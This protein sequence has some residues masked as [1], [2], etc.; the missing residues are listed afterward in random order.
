MK[1]SYSLDE[2]D[3]ARGLAASQAQAAANRWA[4]SIAIVDAGGHL[5]AFLRLDG[6]AP[7]SAAVAIDKARTA[8][9]GRR[10]SKFY[11]DAVKG[12]RLALLSIPGMVTLEG[13]VP[14]VVGD[15]CVGAV[16]VS[17]VKSPEDAQIAAAAV[18]AILAND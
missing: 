3:A 16:G 9:I 12:G 7:L 5:V 1:A 15:Q 13:G 6:A 8:A 11:D 14:I 18:R 2:S 4:V 10:E 17:G